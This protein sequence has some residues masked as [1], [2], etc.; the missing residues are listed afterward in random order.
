VKLPT[1]KELVILGSVCLVATILWLWLM[2]PHNWHDALLV[3][4]AGLAG[5]T[6]TLVWVG[7]VN[8][9]PTEEKDDKD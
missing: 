4:L 3:L 9:L 1:K 2:E 5:I 7:L 6:G 8:T